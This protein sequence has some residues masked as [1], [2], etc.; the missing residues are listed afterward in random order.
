M[1]RNALFGFGQPAF[2][3]GDEPESSSRCSSAR[4]ASTSSPV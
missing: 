4:A 1:A 3:I 2:S